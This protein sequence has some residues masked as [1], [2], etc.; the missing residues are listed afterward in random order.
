M[1]FDNTE[2]EKNYANALIAEQMADKDEYIAEALAAV[3]I[4]KKALRKLT[5]QVLCDHDFKLKT[6]SHS[7]HYKCKKCKFEF[8]S[9]PDKPAKV[10][11]VNRQLDPMKFDE[12]YQITEDDAPQVA[13]NY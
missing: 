11:T 12:L 13:K 5:K 10:S 3:K 7:D 9:D 4:A 6:L 1:I 8:F 2:Q